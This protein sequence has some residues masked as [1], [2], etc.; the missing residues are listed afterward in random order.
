MARLNYKKQDVILITEHTKCKKHP[1]LSEL[2]YSVV[3]YSVVQSRPKGREELGVKTAGKRCTK[4]RSGIFRA[5]GL[6]VTFSQR[7]LPA[8]SALERAERFLK[9]TV[10]SVRM[11]AC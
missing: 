1:V 4:I 6:K 5:C 9:R 10:P 7:L 3:E 11:T 8:S 2:E